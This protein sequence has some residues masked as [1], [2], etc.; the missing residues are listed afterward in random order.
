MRCQKHCHEDTIDEQTDL[1]KG[2]D[3]SMSLIE[4]K[5]DIKRPF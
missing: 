4:S 1:V 5:K 2:T 3:E